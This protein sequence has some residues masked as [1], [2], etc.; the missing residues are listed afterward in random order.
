[1][2]IEY[3]VRRHALLGGNERARAVSL[4]PHDAPLSSDQHNSARRLVPRNR[5]RYHLVHARKPL[6]RHPDRFGARDGKRKSEGLK[7]ESEEKKE[8][9]GDAESGR[10]EKSLERIKFLS[11]HTLRRGQAH[12]PDLR[13]I[14]C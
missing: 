12:L 6:R 5:L 7:S 4:A 11:H 3:G 1:G 8:R 2:D 10:R 14:H 9:R 13:D